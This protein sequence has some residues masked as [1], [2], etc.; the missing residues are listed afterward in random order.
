MATPGIRPATTAD[1]VV[2]Q[3]IYATEVRQQTASFEIAAPSLPVIQAR[4]L[5]V[6][7]MGLPYV[8]AECDGR[9]AG[10][11]YA[12]LLYTSDAADE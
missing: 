8:V 1:L 5:A 12:C 7:D 3:E 11:A 2:V 9:I 4:W 6:T 10:Y